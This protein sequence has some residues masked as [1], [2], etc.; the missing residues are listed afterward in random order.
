[1]TTKINFKKTQAGR[2]TMQD[3]FDDDGDEPGG[4]VVVILIII[5]ILMCLARTLK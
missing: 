4:C 1:M 5:F 2:M 3:D